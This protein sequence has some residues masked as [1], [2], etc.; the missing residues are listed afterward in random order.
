[1]DIFIFLESHHQWQEI[2]DK[3]IVL[4]LVEKN[5]IV[6]RF[7]QHPESGERSKAK[8]AGNLCYSEGK[9]KSY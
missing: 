9:K 6:P 5:S 4:G 1:M 3:L 8:H 2:T 7:L